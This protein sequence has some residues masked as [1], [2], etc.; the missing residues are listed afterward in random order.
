MRK[1]TK[2]L[3][4][5]LIAV[6]GLF[7]VGCKQDPAEVLDAAKT[8][9]VITY[10]TG[11]SATSVT[12]NV[13]L[14]TTD[15]DVVITWSSSDTTVIANDGTVT[16]G[17]E[18]ASIILTATL[19]Y[20][21]TTVTKAFSLTVIGDT[22]IQDALDAAEDA[23][24]AYYAETIGSDTYVVSGNLTL[25]ATIGNDGATVTWAS[26]DT[27]YVALDG[28]VTMPSFTAGDQNVTLT[29]TISY[30]GLTTQVTLYAYLEKLALSNAERAEQALTRAVAFPAND[31][32][33]EDVDF[34]A[35]ALDDDGN[36]YAVTWT[37]S[38]LA[39]IAADGTVTQPM[40]ADTNVVVTAS[41]T[42]EGV[43]YTKTYTFIVLKYD[44]G[45]DV[46]TI[47]AAIALGVDERANYVGMTVV[48]IYD[49]GAFFISDGT[50]VM[51][52]YSGS[53]DVELG[54]VYDI[55]G[56]LDIYS[57]QYEITGYEPIIITESTATAVGMPA[58]TVATVSE[59]LEDNP[60]VP[61]GTNPYHYTVYTVTGKVYYDTSVSD[62]YSVFLV[63]TD[64]DF[65]TDLVTVNSDD[66][67]TLAD[68]GI[69][70]YHSANDEDLK[71]LHGQTV[72]V[73][74]LMVGYRS[75][76]KVYYGSFFGTTSDITVVFESD[77]AAADAVATAIKNTIPTFVLEDTDLELLASLYGVDLTYAS[78]DPTI[79]SVAGLIDVDAV[80]IQTPVDFTITATKGEATAEVTVTIFV[81]DL[82]FSDIADIHD[83]L[84]IAEGDLVK[85]QGIITAMT[86]YNNFWIQDAT[87]GVDIYVSSDY[88][89][90]FAS[91]VGQEVILYG[92]KDVYKGLY[93]IVNIVSVEVVDEEP[94]AITPVSLTGIDIIAEN[95]ADYQGQLVSFEGCILKS[96]VSFTTNSFNFYLL[97]VA[98]GTTITGRVESSI[99]EDEF[100]AIV[101]FLTGLDAGDP[102]DVVGAILSWYNTPQIAIALSSNL[103]AGTAISDQAMADYEASVLTMPAATATTDFT[104]TVAGKYGA[105]V[106]WTSD[107]AAIVIDGASATVTR[108]ASGQPDAVVTLSYTVTYGDTNATATGTTTVTVTAEA[109]VATV[110]SDLFFSE[111]IEGSSN[112]KALEIYNG[113]GVTVDLSIY[114]VCLYSNGSATATNTLNLTGTL[115][116]GEVYVIANSS[117]AQ[118][119]LDVSDTTSTVTY[120]N[121]DDAIALLKNDVVIDVIGV[122]G[123]DPGT[124]WPVGDGS[125]L[126]HTLVRSAAVSDPNTTFTAS[127][128]VVYDIDTFTYLGSHTM[129]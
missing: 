41:I 21:E 28:T 89:D 26:S 94:T 64:Y 27:D 122:I 35:T 10:A 82:P 46:T 30:G 104:L 95:V 127:E 9:L 66:S 76:F 40:D 125:T 25:V 19:T 96:T 33:Y 112:S 60:T 34:V 85:V 51:Y 91:L 72:T 78:E 17:T 23:L 11:D 5:A 62:D 84:V 45:T 55:S 8:N 42:I 58:G 18:D 93:E 65:N 43:V 4:F 54:G 115:A 101:A 53:Y 48:A 32:I 97:D 123:S 22:S 81:G 74:I 116:P 70:L 39:L 98:T 108:P 63:P 100:T 47:A 103:V 16:R 77:Q 102:V 36:S 31:G 7:L 99:D 113:T 87:G 118:A 12:G 124:N 73:D 90:L 2:F 1:T 105:T 114:T 15:G 24:I 20:E 80:T 38:N 61:T 69:M 79:I 111:Y 71:P 83:D 106:A 119:I 52:V 117:S 110:A 128:W 88:E 59:V 29:A 44:L 107:N 68:D 13:T 57:A 121:G 67:Y 37:T 3:A 92:E 86:K 109:T 50:D 129:D 126:D 75:D 49:W 120:F 6:F 56:V 14:P